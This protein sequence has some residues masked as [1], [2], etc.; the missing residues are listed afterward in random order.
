MSKPSFR[1]IGGPKQYFKYSECEKGQV[2]VEGAKYIGR[3]PNKFGNE[4][5]DFKP[6]EGGPII[7]LNSAGQ[8]NW[9]MENHVVEGDL[10]RVVYEGKSTIETK[11][12]AMEGK[13][14]HSFTVEVA[15]ST[16]QL[17]ASAVKK[18]QDNMESDNSP[19]DMSDL[20]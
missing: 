16:E 17:D 7:C 9:L 6:L 11:G 8:L 10:V 15:E 5:H 13:E 4:N 20:D 18:V 2:L 1:K 3:S 19:V 12:H 14:A